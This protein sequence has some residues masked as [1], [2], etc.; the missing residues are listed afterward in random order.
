VATMP[1]TQLIES[2]AGS[3]LPGVGRQRP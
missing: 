1:F 2:A 3:N